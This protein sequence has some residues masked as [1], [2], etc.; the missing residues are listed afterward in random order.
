[1]AACAAA[2]LSAVYDQRDESCGRRALICRL[3]I[4]RPA[5]SVL[6]KSRLGEEMF[7]WRD[8]LS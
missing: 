8:E 6:R 4:G 1:M 3:S 5:L 7:F 2:T